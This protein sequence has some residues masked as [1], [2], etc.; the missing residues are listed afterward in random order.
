M[1]QHL[2]NL[3]IEKLLIHRNCLIHFLRL[4]TIKDR[5]M[6]TAL[7]MVPA[8]TCWV[9]IYGLQRHRF[10]KC[11]WGDSSQAT[12]TL[13]LVYELLYHGNLYK[14]CSQPGE[15]LPA[16]NTLSVYSI[17]TRKFA[18]HQEGT[19]S[20][21]DVAENTEQLFTG[22]RNTKQGLKSCFEIRCSKVLL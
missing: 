4:L 22:P 12:A 15:Q 20:S 1:W 17:F 6:Q 11:V 9:E 3:K 10:L 8:K 7:D 21:R 5:T 19:S 2:I 16:L 18:F 13:S 14:Q